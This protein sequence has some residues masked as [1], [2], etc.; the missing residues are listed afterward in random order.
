MIID[1]HT[2]APNKHTDPQPTSSHG[3]LWNRATRR[4]Y[5]FRNNIHNGINR[6]LQK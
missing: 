6:I 3:V 5:Y 1:D 2:K 4:A